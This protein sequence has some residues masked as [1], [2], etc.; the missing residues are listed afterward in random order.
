MKQLLLVLA[1]LL[2]ACSPSRPDYNLN[3]ESMS[4]KLFIVGSDGKDIDPLNGEMLELN[5]AIIGLGAIGLPPGVH[6]VG[7]SCPPTGGDT[8]VLVDVLPRVTATFEIGKSYEL[9]C[10]NGWPTIS[11]RPSHQ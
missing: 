1:L 7:Y 4:S 8:T 6:H 5:D 2:I 10:V 3:F 11:A 9:R